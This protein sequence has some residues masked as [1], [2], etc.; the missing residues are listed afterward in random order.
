M[1]DTR[2]HILHVSFNLFLQKSFKEVTMQEIVEKT[3]M[4]KGAFY[5]YFNSK[6]QL[7]LEV[8]NHYL[9]EL[10]I[11]YTKLSHESLFQFYHDL[12]N[13]MNDLLHS[14]LNEQN[15]DLDL[16]FYTLMFDA[17]KLF[18]SF[19]EQMSEHFQVERNA[20]IE[21]IRLARSKGEIRSPLT[22][23]QIADLFIYTSDGVGMHNI[24]EGRIVAMT[25]NLL[26]VWDVLYKGLIT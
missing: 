13:R 2:E 17:M 25:D 1:K 22:D 4:S 9:N 8:A 10:T 18:P 19:R 5:H 20:W 11:D 23:A 16:N 7:F 21:M 12:I 14:F 15:G 6:E 24:L 3:G 26:A